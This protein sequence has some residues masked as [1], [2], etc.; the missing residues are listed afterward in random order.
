MNEKEELEKLKN[1]NNT[2]KQ[3]L[4][5]YIPRRRVRRIFKSLKHVLEQDIITENKEHITHLKNII[6]KYRKKEYVDSIII[7]EKTIIAIEHLI[8][9]YDNTKGW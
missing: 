4:K 6:D 3:Q 1:E 9:F 5:N 2:L 8:G 7:D